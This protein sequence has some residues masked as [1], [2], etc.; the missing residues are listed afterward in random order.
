MLKYYK[1]IFTYISMFSWPEAWWTD[2]SVGKKALIETV[3]SIEL[4]QKQLD[5]IKSELKAMWNTIENYDINTWRR[6]EIAKINWAENK[7]DLSRLQNKYTQLQNQIKQESRDGRVILSGSIKPVKT[8]ETG[9]IT[10]DRFMEMITA[11]IKI[12]DTPWTWASWSNWIRDALKLL[13]WHIDDF[14]PSEYNKL[15]WALNLIKNRFPNTKD[16]KEVSKLIANKTTLKTNYDFADELINKLNQKLTKDSPERKEEA[17][18]VIPPATDVLIKTIPSEITP[19][20]KWVT[21]FDTLKDLWIDSPNTW[22]KNTE[23]KITWT[24]SKYEKV[25]NNILQINTEKTVKPSFKENVPWVKKYLEKVFVDINNPT[26]DEIIAVLEK[27]KTTEFKWKKWPE[28]WTSAIFAIQWA[29]QLLWNDIT[30]DWMYWNETKKIIIEFQ[31]KNKL[32]PDWIPGEK[33]MTA[34]L[35]SLEK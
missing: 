26:K 18:K 34:L 15:I 8:L 35:K 23:T 25:D 20:K 14:A 10:S 11:N 24:E 27:F 33:T 2:L 7:D 28:W 12:A 32:K 30:V 5:E 22:V 13:E 9:Y 16:K 1:N 4:T 3:N 17:P 31:T 6:W 19:E 21:I 29:L